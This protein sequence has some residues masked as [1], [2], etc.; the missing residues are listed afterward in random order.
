MLTL[1]PARHRSLA[2]K[3]FLF[4]AALLI[5]V[6]LVMFAYDV[7][8]GNVSIGKS[9]L[10]IGV[11]LLIAGVLAW[12]TMRILG[13]PMQ[14][15]QGALQA[16]SEGRLERIRY[17]KTGDEIEFVVTARFSRPFTTVETA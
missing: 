17:R 5:W 16:V 10:L 7:A 8:Y 1:G 3:F 13:K 14:I 12:V 6:V 4:T 11:V 9:V 15:L 2:T